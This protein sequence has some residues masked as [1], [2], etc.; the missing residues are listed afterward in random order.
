MKTWKKVALTSVT[1]M[2]AATLVA[3]G[4]SSSKG[5][6]KK[7]TLT[8]ANWNLGTKA[9]NG[10]ERQLIAAWNKANPDV[11]VKIDEKLSGSTT[12]TDTLNTE[13]SAGKLPDVFMSASVAD[14]TTSGW[15]ADLTKIEKADK[16]FKALPEVV[17][18][19]VI[20][21]G[22]NVAVPFGE[23]EMGF[24]VNDDLLNKL[25]LTVP[26][27]NTSVDDFVKTVKAATNLSQ[28]YVGVSEA[29]SFTDWLPAQL[30]QDLGWFTYNDGK[31]NLTA[32]EMTQAMSIASD[33]GKNGYSF[34][35]LTAEQ[36]K[37]LSG[38][39]DA[40]A[41]FKKGNVAFLYNGTY[42][43]ADLQSGANFNYSFMGLPGGR[44][45]ME[46]DYTIVAKTSK[47]KQDAYDF[48]KYMAY[49]ESGYKERLAL[50]KKSGTTPAYLPLTTNKKLVSEYWKLIA[51]PGM[52][53]VANNT[54]NAMVDPIKTVPGY[55]NARWN[56]T[57]G[58][59]VAG[60]DNAT[61]GDII[62]ASG[63]GQ[64]NW[65]DYAQ[66]IQTLA[67]KQLDDAAAKLK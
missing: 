16:D 21:G 66:Q 63:L 19:S 47:H 67:Q 23:S 7:V 32:P 25:N 52:Q 49:G 60:K 39:T 35:Q 44:E 18:E 12:Y 10:V 13:A 59:K 37:A 42:A 54:K 64:V 14:N 28:K 36:Q 34:A 6:S 55:I 51:V 24:F 50:T 45:D 11:Q 46:L 29:P 57:T 2:A 26:D 65:S 20:L 27:Y 31:V 33:L 17:Q 58:L 8:Y 56:A 62:N 38:G 3:C 53:D 9:Q 43:A 5:E 48:A 4:S 22:K 1:M 15:A 30:N 40:N 41:A 61:I